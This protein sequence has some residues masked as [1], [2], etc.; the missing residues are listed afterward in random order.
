MNFS[1]S[2]QKKLHSF[3]MIFFQAWFFPYYA[4]TPFHYRYADFGLHTRNVKLERPKVQT[5]DGRILQGPDMKRV[6]LREPKLRLVTDTFGYV[7]LFPLLL[8][9]LRPDS[10]HLKQILTDLTNEDLLWTPYGLRSLAKNAP[11]YMVRNTEHD[12]PYW[13]GAVWL[14]V[15]FLCLDALHYYAETP[16]PHRDFAFEVYGKLRSGLVSN[17]LRQFRQTGYLWEHYNDATGAG[18]GTHPFTGWTSLVL[19]MMSENY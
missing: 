2:F 6:V 7:S 11:L 5:K 10:P 13:R 4:I 1:E 8:R 17:V 19:L 3:K 15:N 18:E 9:V 16:G 14:N 12:P